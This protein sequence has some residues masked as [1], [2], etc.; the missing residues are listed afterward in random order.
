MEV[1]QTRYKNYYFRSRTEARWAVFFDTLRI[2]Y[3][4]EPQGF[5]L[6]DGTPY[7]PDFWLPEL[8]LWVEVKGQGPNDE[9]A[10]KAQRL[11]DGSGHRVLLVAGSPQNPKYARPSDH[12]TYRPNQVPEFAKLHEVFGFATP[13]AAGL[14]AAYGEAMSARFEHGESPRARFLNR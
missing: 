6:D 3:E 10:N 14:L 4:Y 12:L 7:L 13:R 5:R 11:A 1:L 9:E 2:V 8:S